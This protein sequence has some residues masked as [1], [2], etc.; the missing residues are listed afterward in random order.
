MESFSW[1]LTFTSCCS[2]CTGRGRKKDVWHKNLSITKYHKVV[3][4]EGLQAV[5]EKHSDT[6]FSL[7]GKHLI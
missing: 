3:L 1:I 6:E 2:I 5:L 7:K 4:V